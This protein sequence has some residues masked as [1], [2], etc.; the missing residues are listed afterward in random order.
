MKKEKK[1]KE[2]EKVKA[3]PKLPKKRHILLTDV[4]IQGET[5]KKGDSIWLTDAG[6]KYFKSLNYI[7]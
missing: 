4:S 3:A 1:S 5:A 7:K 2:V 6:S